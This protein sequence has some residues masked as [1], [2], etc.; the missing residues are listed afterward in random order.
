MGSLQMM[1]EE[2]T[3]SYESQQ[4]AKMMQVEA[5]KFGLGQVQRQGDIQREAQ[6]EETKFQRQL[7]LEEMGFDRD[8]AKLQAQQ[9]FTRQQSNVDYQRDL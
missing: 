6:Q 4:N 8:M 7:Q 1:T 3:A 2:A 9:D 5:L